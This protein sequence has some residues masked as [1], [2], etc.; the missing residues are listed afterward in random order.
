MT[1]PSAPRVL[2][3]TDAVGGVWNF[4]GMLATALARQGCRILL[5]SMGPAPRR[6]HA[7]PLTGISGLQLEIT[8]FALE[9]MDPEGADAGRTRHGLARLARVFRPDVVHLN[10]YR[11]ACAEWRAPVLVVAHSCVRSWWQ[12][13]H[14]AEPNEAHWRTYM[15]NVAAGLAA[16]DAWAAPS[17]AFRDTISGLYA[18]PTAGLVI[19]NGHDLAVPVT[20]KEPF[21]LA[22]GRLWDE[23]KNIRQLGSIA[24]ALPWPVRVAGA[25]RSGDH[26]AALGANLDVLGD[27]P[28][29]ALLALMRRAAIF[30]APAL[31][32][33]F[34]LTVLEAATAGCALVL[35][36]I[37]TFRELWDGAALFVDPRS[38]SALQHAILR[39]AEDAGLRTAFQSAARDRAARY[40]LAATV[41]GYCSV[42][43]R[44]HRPAMS[45]Q[46]V[47]PG[48]AMAAGAPP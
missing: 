16:A 21:I 47:R 6:D 15:R 23:A 7:A 40:P 22:A 48:W 8:D 37:A 45:A 3:T 12:A 2:M 9:W 39:V 4:T 27:L 5:V 17:A 42:Y 18:P 25:A 35:S 13:C 11:E 32:E 28:R 38:P 20:P 36:D 10:G 41:A 34:G 31:Y 1:P 30:V 33:P 43:D 26:V 24:D 44:M 29:P 19:R 46:E 14:G